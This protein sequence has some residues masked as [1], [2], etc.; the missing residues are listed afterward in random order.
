MLTAIGNGRRFC[1]WH[2]L[3]AAEPRRSILNGL[4]VNSLCHLSVLCDSVVDRNGKSNHH[5]DAENTNVAPRNP[6]ES[7]YSLLIS[8][9]PEGETR[10]L[11]CYWRLGFLLLN[12]KDSY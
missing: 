6:L 1:F 12:K 5:E 11:V 7:T 9:R 2:S 3:R 8:R 4:I 10:T